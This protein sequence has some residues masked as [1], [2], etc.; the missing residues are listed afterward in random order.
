MKIKPAQ[1]HSILLL[2]ILVM[3]GVSSCST[4]RNTAASRAYHTLTSHY[5]VYWNGLNNLNEGIAFLE[6]NR[7]DRFDHTLRVFNYGDEK[8]AKQLKSKM[9]RTIKKAS[10]GIQHHSMVFNG[11]E[12]IRWVEESY[13]L[14]GKA[15]F[16]AHDYVPAKRVFDFVAKKYLK[17]PI[18]YKG[19]LWLAKTA[20]E[21][22][23][24]EK[25]EAMLNL[26]NSQ[27]DA[28]DFPVDVKNELPLVMADFYLAR[29]D[30]Q[31]AY[32]YLEKSLRLVRNRDMRSR[33][34]FILGQIDQKNGDLQTA[35]S[36]FKKV[37]KLN[38]P[39]QMAF[40]ARLNLATSYDT[41]SGDRKEITK[42]LEKMARKN[43][44]EDYR[45]Q[46]YFALASI[47]EKNHQD[48]LMV[49]HLKKS[50][51]FAKS[52]RYQKATSA[53][54]LADFLFASGQYVVA[55]AYYDTAVSAFPKDYPNFDYLKQK[56][57]ILSKMVND[58]QTV[59][60]QDS[61]QQTAR[62]DSS[63]LYA[64]INVRIKAYQ[65]QLD[66]KK[67]AA[68]IALANT[69]A[70][71]SNPKGDS[72]QGFSPGGGWY[73][74]NNQAKSRGYSDFVK[75]WGNRKL[76]DLWF[77]SEKQIQQ[78]VASDN[79]VNSP[80]NSTADQNRP[81]PEKDPLQAAFYLKGL[82]QTPNDFK[83]SDSLIM[84][85]YHRLGKVYLEDLHDSV[86]ALDIYSKLDSRYPDNPYQLENWYHLYKIYRGLK[87]DS[88]ALSYKR[89][90]LKG[91]PAS[92]Y[93]RVLSDPDY[94]KKLEKSKQEA[95]RLYGRTY[96]AFEHE[97]FY[98]VLTYVRR[99]KQQY[100]GDTALM[101]K[102][103]YLQAM[104]IGKLDVP[105]SLY[106]YMQLFVKQ[107]P[108][109]P[110]TK[111]SKQVIKM[112]QKDYGIGISEAE[113]KAMQA[114]E[115]ASR[116][117]GPY[118]FEGKGPQLVM[119]VS[120][121]KQV[122]TRSLL[123][124]LGDFNQKYFRQKK[125][126]MNNLGLDNSRQ[127]IS[128]GNFTIPEAQAYFKKLRKDAYV[129]SGISQEKYTLFII[130][131]KNYPLFYREKKIE[132]YQQFFQKYYQ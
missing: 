129:F 59:R 63:A 51:Q 77:I 112:L 98:R 114:K 37:I 119:I 71:A 84:M 94:Y 4:K 18:H 95:A 102:F 91:Y 88:A 46:I 9:N 103:L 20:I 65:K 80:A 100:A 11:K 55:Q 43:Q 21:T 27:L 5:N 113:H 101:P 42:A 7:N 17:Q 8:L 47:A 25:A 39:F 41:L 32:P 45:D 127:L 96:T 36:R 29:Q 111:R 57:A 118:V 132:Q 82:P 1:Q 86:H 90:I 131:V 48:S 23:Q 107:Y 54:K 105:D 16:Y 67:E 85:A 123:T 99:A 31:L 93:A 12:Q 126:Q 104:A 108:H 68:D 76:E 24:F 128:I 28:V 92:L 34:L 106:R 115:L 66:A 13:L 72:K 35:S 75:R 110:L 10:M 60:K 73:F 3:I 50:V 130:S 97:Q 64:L 79:S 33:I 87:Q 15:Y 44:Y 40:E 22:A 56:A 125:L 74:Y 49:L 62:L 109:H 89:K 19:M 2:I 120:D 70:N 116:A 53:L 69:L 6:K 38:P 81:D 61:L 121:R 83:R 26:L 30:E 52:N 122:D 78:S 117:L 58:L 124:R 14:M